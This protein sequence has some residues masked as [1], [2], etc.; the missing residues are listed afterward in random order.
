[1]KILATADTHI[2]FRQ[3]GLLSREHDIE[4][5]FLKL[6]NLGVDLQVNAITVS[7][8]ILHTVRPTAHSVHY[9][10]T[11]QEFLITNKLVCLVSVGNHDKSSP[12]WIDTISTNSEYGF[13]ILDD[14]TFA[15]DEDTVI[16][17][18]TFCSREEFDKGS[19][20]LLYTSDAADE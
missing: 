2:G 7:G 9:L 18:K 12:H 3:Y 20:C 5:S 15:L 6:L 4:Q 19:T 14:T 11:C 1:M 13:K 17:G 10:K 16:Y 8:D